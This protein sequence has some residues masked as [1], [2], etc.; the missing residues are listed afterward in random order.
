MLGVL[1]MAL[2]CRLLFL[3]M[4]PSDDIHRYIWEGRVQI[5][6]INPYKVSPSDPSLKYLQDASWSA[7][8]HPKETA[9]YPPGIELLFSILTRITT[10]PFDF[11]VL[12]ALI[13]MGS[14]LVLLSLLRMTQGH[15]KWALLY[16]VNPVV[17]LA[18]AGEGHLDALMIFFML[19]TLWCFHKKKWK[20]MFLMAAFSFH[21][22]YTAC[23]LWP[24]LFQRTTLKYSWVLI[25]TTIIPFLCFGSLV[26]VGET[27]YTFTT[28][29][30]FNSSLHYILGTFL[31]SFSLASYVCGLT[32]FFLIIFFRYKID[33]PIQ[34]SLWGFGSLLLLAPTVHF[35]YLT[36]IIPFLC[37]VPSP[38]WILFCGTLAFSFASQGNMH[39]TGTWKEF[40]MITALEYIPVY[41]LLLFS[42]IRNRLI[43]ISERK[44]QNP[45]VQ[46][47]SMIVPTL[48]EEKMVHHFF[49]SI[50]Q[51]SLQPLEVIVSDG[52]SL[53][54]TVPV[55]K[56]WGATL[57]HSARGRGTQ[58]CAGIE[59]AKGD[60]L[61]LVHAD[62]S[63]EQNCLEQIIDA[64]NRTG[65]SAGAVGSTFD[66]N[67][68]FLR[69][70]TIL[71]NIRTRI[72]GIIFSDQ[73]I[74]VR[75]DQLKSLG[76]FPHMPIME[77]IEF[78][79]RLKRQEHPIF[80]GGG[81]RVSNRRWK[82][83]SKWKHTLLILWLVTQYLFIRTWK[84]EMINVETFYKRYYKKSLSA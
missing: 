78:S 32:L 61:F 77:D 25:G 23:I 58:I 55:A 74:F 72:V 50:E 16:A 75:R 36:W 11:K 71:N 21:V 10:R 19:T 30:H 6:G 49:R 83:R 82:E 56:Q 57:V 67:N 37:F 53:D 45:P 65:K 35:W 76:G 80:L 24:F 46:T 22:K 34:G 64:V 27:L 33:D 8:N 9:I 2:V 14:I 18:F 13:D 15:P 42:V 39:A 48:N 84:G 73:G 40:H 51:L 31:G 20:T 70:I 62:M 3:P 41:G 79:I 59:K 68:L 26:E 4:E 66:R 69:F 43:K 44:K 81:I 5:E 28:T 17:L 38:A 52:G 47:V 54:R 7:I 63:F 1:L 60:I 12:F 29:L